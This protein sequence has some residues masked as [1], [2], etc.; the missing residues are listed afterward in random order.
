VSDRLLNADDVAA[1]TGLKRNWVYAETR[2]G[3]IPH[4]KLGRTYRYRR[5][6]IERWLTAIERGA[7]IVKDDNQ[8]PGP[9]RNGSR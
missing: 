3:R 2:A 8:P 1:L 5:E 7:D 4:I 9:A 6:S